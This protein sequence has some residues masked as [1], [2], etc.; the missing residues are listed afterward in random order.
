MCFMMSTITLQTRCPYPIPT[1]YTGYECGG[2]G[3][4]GG[5]AGTSFIIVTPSSTSTKPTSTKTGT[6]CTPTVTVR[7]NLQVRD[8]CAFECDS[9]PRCIGD[10]I[11]PLPC[12]CTSAASVFTSTIRACPTRSPCI[13]CS[14]G[15][16]W[17]LPASNCPTT[18][19]GAS[20]TQLRA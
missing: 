16:G 18:T 17:T 7:E 9:E 14:I 10:G 15:F 19:Q 12:G 20:T 8:G 1:V 13:N 4:P 6:A 5:C 3:C 11:I 2:K